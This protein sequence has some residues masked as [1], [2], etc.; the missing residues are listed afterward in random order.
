MQKYNA[1]AQL[2]PDFVGQIP[3][4]SVCVP[5]RD[6]QSLFS[7]LPPEYKRRNSRRGPFQCWRIGLPYP[8]VAHVRARSAFRGAM[9]T[10]V[11]ANLTD[12]SSVTQRLVYTHGLIL[13]DDFA[14]T[15][16]LRGSRPINDHICSNV[17]NSL[18]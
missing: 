5:T 18:T 12:W 10:R 1:T 16:R 17:S 9:R 14:R 7:R 3:L 13:A 8:T 4:S 2:I 11:H 6:E 15:G